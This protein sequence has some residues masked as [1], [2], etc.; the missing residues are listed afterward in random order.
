ML[1]LKNGC[2]HPT[3][4]QPY[5][6]SLT[7]GLNNSPEGRNVSPNREVADAVIANCV[8]DGLTHAFV[9]EFDNGGD[10]DYYVKDDPVHQD[11][12]NQHAPNFEKVCVVDYAVG[13]FD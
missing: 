2:L 4:K 1:A 12:I 5:I 6:R 11:F 13:Q 3:T 8:E 7:G 10:R 9:V